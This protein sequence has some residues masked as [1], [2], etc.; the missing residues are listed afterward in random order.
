MPW[1]DPLVGE[2]GGRRLAELLALLGL[3]VLLGV[4]WFARFDPITGFVP[5]T[6][7]GLYLYIGQQ[8]LRGAAPYRDVF[9][10]K[11]PLLYL[12]NAFGLVLGGGSFWGVYALEYVLLSVTAALAYLI[13]KV[14]VGR[15]AALLAVLFFVLEIAHVVAGDHEEEYEVVVQCLALFALC[16]R[17]A[18]EPR[19][20]WWFVAGVL[21]TGAFLLK[22]TGVGFWAALL[23]AVALVCLRS[24]QW[25]TW[26]P[27]LWA[28]AGG[29]VLAG[30]ACLAYLGAVGALHP[31]VADYFGF[32]IMYSGHSGAADRLSSVWY[33]AGRLGYLAVAA[34]LVAWLLTA[35]RVVRRR[36]SLEGADGLALVCVI[37]LPVEVVLAATSGYSRLQYYFL[38]LLPA[39]MLLAYGLAQLSRPAGRE[40]AAGR[41]QPSR[42]QP[43]RSRLS[44][45]AALLAVAAFAGLLAP[46]ATLLHEL[47]GSLVHHRLYAARRP[48]AEQIAAY[49]D[50]HTAPD[51][52]VL[53]WGG[54]DAT[55]NFLAKRRSPTRYPMQLALYYPDYA[56]TGVPE[57]LREL[58]ADP[59]ALILD[60]SP[61]YG[62]QW[63]TAV[64]SLAA[65]SAQWGSSPP[66]VRTAWASVST[67][68]H[69]RY[70]RVGTLG[71]APEWPVYVRR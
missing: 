18:I 30:A 25:R 15:L 67:Y 38:W 6:D 5:H 23:V 55:I 1:R 52:K 29:A 26:L 63:G 48:Q 60:S 33:G 49:V 21:G 10:N 32:N 42:L 71:F 39:T 35:R 28:A 16:R 61:S 22:P 12:V 59:P 17:P 14:R 43:G 41:V 56:A 64:P 24:G 66:A 9:D 11:G 68:I 69:A 4:L 37:W 2:R 40:H 13:L 44:L 65:T 50:R 34:V 27:R 31:F 51:A 53:V 3:V 70:R 57:F 36:G 46:T 58:K 54:Y 62:P 19:L 20:R 7:D 45:P 47:G 8:L